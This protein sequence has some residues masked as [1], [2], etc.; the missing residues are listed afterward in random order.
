MG[1]NAKL[2]GKIKGENFSHG[3]EISE[4]LF[5]ENLEN[6]LVLILMVIANDKFIFN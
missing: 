1:E 5:G 3:C 6:S 4:K 2:F